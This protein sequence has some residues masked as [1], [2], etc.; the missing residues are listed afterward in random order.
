MRASTAGFVVAS[1]GGQVL[2]H[3]IVLVDPGAEIPVR[4]G[5][6]GNLDICCKV[7][8][9]DRVSIP[10]GDVTV[11]DDRER[12]LGGAARNRPTTD[13]DSP[14]TAGRIAKPAGLPG[15][16]AVGDRNDFGRR[17]RS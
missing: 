13:S 4:G 14:D 17:P 3:E 1:V 8:D 9:V 16:I 5:G 15:A 2:V 11:D 6:V 12:D 7:G 10:H